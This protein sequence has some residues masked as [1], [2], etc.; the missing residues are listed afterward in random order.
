VKLVVME[1]KK[2]ESTSTVAAVDDRLK[3]RS[4]A[5]K[6]CVISTPGSTIRT[7]KVR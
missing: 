5:R 2:K 3:L 6:S 4:H 1:R 7:I